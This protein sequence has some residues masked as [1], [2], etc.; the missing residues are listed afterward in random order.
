VL[1]ARDAVVYI[2]G[3]LAGPNSVVIVAERRQ[4]AWW[5]E[6]LD[7]ATAT[8]TAALVASL[9]ER[10]GMVDRLADMAHTD[11]LTGMPNRRALFEHLDQQASRSRRDRAPFCVAIF[12]LDHF[13]RF[14]DSFGHPAGDRML[15]AFAST[16]SERV[17]GQDVFARLGGE[18][19]CLVLPDTGVDGSVHLIGELQAQARPILM[20]PDG[21]TVTFSVGVAECR[22]NEDISALLARADVA[23]YE[24][25]HS[26]RDRVVADVIN[27]RS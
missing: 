27:L 14:N 3:P 11:D 19:F 26:G 17:R 20:G 15:K 4:P 8:T 6:P 10:S 23:L 25:K 9:A 16:I 5:S 24:A 22:P 21:N 18:E 2:S 12:D 13:K 1:H 7:D